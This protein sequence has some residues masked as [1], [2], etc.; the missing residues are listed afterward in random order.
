MLAFPESRASRARPVCQ[1][2]MDC[3]ETTAYLDPTV[4]TENRES[5]GLLAWTAS[6]DRRDPSDPKETTDSRELRA[7]TDCR[8]FREPKETWESPDCRVKMDCR[9]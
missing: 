9:D 7:K 2:E 3:Q 8:D 1:A 4:S 6:P 5:R